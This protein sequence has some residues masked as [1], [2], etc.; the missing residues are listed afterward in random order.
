MLCVVVYTG[1]SRNI[2]KL[3]RRGQVSCI[4]LSR[5]ISEKPGIALAELV[6]CF[7]PSRKISANLGIALAEQ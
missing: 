3:F 5:H 7:D 2:L 6:C 1:K 4:G